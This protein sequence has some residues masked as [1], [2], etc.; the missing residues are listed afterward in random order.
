MDRV[1]CNSSNI[2]VERLVRVGYYELEQTIGKGNFAVV[3]LATHV[4]TNTKVFIF[5]IKII[6]F[7]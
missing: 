3:K 5:L 1:N 6:I 4:V 7:I 2:P